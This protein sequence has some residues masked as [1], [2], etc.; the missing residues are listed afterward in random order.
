MAIHLSTNVAELPG[1]GTKA[2]NDFKNLGISSVRDLLLAV[3]FRYDDFSQIKKI[4]E[5]RP[6]HPVTV[7]GTITSIKSRQAKNRHMTIVEATLKDETGT[8][9]ILWFNQE[10]LATTIRPGTELSLSGT[11]DYRFNR[12]MINPVHESPGRHLLTGRIV[13]VYSLSGSLKIHRVRAAVRTALGAVHEFEEWIPPEIIKQENFSDFSTAI[14]SIHFPENQKDLS[15]AIE[16]LKF[17]ELF[18][19]QLMFAQVRRERSTRLASVITIDEEAL[20]RFVKALPFELTLAQKRSAWEI[21]QDLAKPHPMN[22]LLQGDVGS[23]KTVVAAIAA[24]GVI[25]ARKLVVYLAPT[26]ILAMQQF[27]VFTRLF[28]NESV[29]LFTRSQRQVSGSPRL[30]SWTKDELVEAIRN[31]DVHCV[32]GTHALLEDNIELPDLALIIVDEQHRFGVA[33]RHALLQK[34]GEIAPHLLSMTATPIPRSLALTIYGDL[35]VSMINQM[36]KGRK[37]I[38]TAV[39]KESQRAGMWE[40]VRDQI[41]QGRQVYVVCPLID[42]SDTLGAKSVMEVC[43]FFKKHVFKNERVNVLHGKLK[44]DEKQKVIEAFKNKKTDVLVCTTVVEVGVDVPNATVMVVMN[45]E[46]FGLA[47]L[48]Q[49]RGRVGRSDLTSFCYLL[50][51]QTEGKAMERLQL[52]ERIQDGFELAEKDLLLRGAG[53]VFGNAQSGFP[54]FTLATEADV[55]LMKKARDHAVRF[56]QTDSL[57]ETH[58]QIAQR[59]TASFEAVHLE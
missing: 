22:R 8:I 40:H 26:E 49:L 56:L 15:R 13:P 55:D 57:L 59:I 11:V 25:G 46:R 50:P 35:D 17:D 12:A 42:P 10:Y 7:I 30:Q 31:S 51:D 29:A 28:F 32:I 14:T 48:H 44:S 27:E 16:R 5:V 6:G 33:Q 54:D 3:P 38:G 37:P 4:I 24:D 21:V 47:Q 1:I 53:N 36:P 23:G 58:P 39:V 52:L 20:R 2:L 18:L 41:K 19:H 9:P 45:A 34:T 43:A